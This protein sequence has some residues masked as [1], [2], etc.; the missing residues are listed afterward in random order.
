MSLRVRGCRREDRIRFTETRFA[1]LSGR[2]PFRKISELLLR[3]LGLLASLL[4][5]LK[6]G[7]KP[8]SEMLE[9]SG[10]EEADGPSRVVSTAKGPQLKEFGIF[11]KSKVKLS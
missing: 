8:G 9:D 2:H 11:L 5:L 3:G 4:A 1:S 6:A 7:E 10:S